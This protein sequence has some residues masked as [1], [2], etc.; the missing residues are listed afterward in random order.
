[1]KSFVNT[2]PVNRGIFTF[3]NMLNYLYCVDCIRTIG[4]YGAEIINI[5]ICTER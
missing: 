4:V 3:G 1:V 5:Q 2:G